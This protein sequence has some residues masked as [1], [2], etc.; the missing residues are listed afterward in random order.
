M[1]LTRGEDGTYGCAAGRYRLRWG[2]AWSNGK[3]GE[4]A[5]EA[6]PGAVGAKGYGGESVVQVVVGFGVD[7]V[8]LGECAADVLLHFGDA[9]EREDGHI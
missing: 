6:A 1:E 8:G 9:V 5:Q 3:G 2:G 7:R 4:T